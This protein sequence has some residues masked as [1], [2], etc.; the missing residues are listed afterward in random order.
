MSQSGVSC[1]DRPGSEDRPAGSRELHAG[2]VELDVAH[3]NHIGRN[4][5]GFAA[6]K[7]RTDAGHQFLWAEWLGQI[8]IRAQL[9]PDQLVRLIGAS[10]Q[11]DDGHGSVAAQ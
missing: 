8:I 9:E 10:G 6:P 7:H 11:H 2:N 5:G 3:P 1:V 4:P